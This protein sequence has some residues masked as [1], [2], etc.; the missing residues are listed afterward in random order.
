M[1]EPRPDVDLFCEDLGHEV[2][3]GALVRRIARDVGTA[4]DL[5]IQS[6]AGGVGRAVSELKAWQRW[7]AQGGFSPALLVVVLDANSVGAAR[8]HSEIE[9]VLDRSYFRE[10]VIGTPDPYIERWLM[11]DPTGFKRVLGVVPGREP[12]GA[13]KARYKTHLTDVVMNA[14]HHV[15]TTVVED[16]GPDL[17]AEMDLYRAGKQQPELGRFTQGL[18]ASL[19]RLIG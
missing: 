1:A 8:R 2:V 17:V 19:T 5:R 13:D 7:R 12:S 4:V 9:R 15:L 18:K 16:F 3:V 14:G 11:A 6:A 10:V